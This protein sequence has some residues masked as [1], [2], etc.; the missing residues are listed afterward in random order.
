MGRLWDNEREIIAHTLERVNWNKY[1]AAQVL[2]IARSTL[3]GKIKK[4]GLTPGGE[5]GLAGLAENLGH[6]AQAQLLLGPLGRGH[7]EHV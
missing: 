4:H 3:Y 5:R 1:R 6:L 2:G 7:L